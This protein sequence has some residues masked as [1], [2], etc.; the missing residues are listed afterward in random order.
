MKPIGIFAATRWELNAIRRAGPSFT[1]RSVNGIR[2]WVGAVG[3]RSC[4][5][6]RT[7]I[8]P[9]KAADISRNILKVGSLSCMISSGFACALNAAT[10]GDVL[11]GTEVIEHPEGK[12]TRP[13]PCSSSLATHAMNTADAV[14]LAAAAGRFVS[15]ARVMCRGEEKRGI[16]R[17]TQGLGLDM[18]SAALAAAAQEAGISFAIIRTVSDVR[19]EDLPLDFNLFLR[20]TGWISGVASCLR[21]P[22][23]V[24]GLSRLRRQSHLAGMHLTQFYE[25]FLSVET[26]ATFT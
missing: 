2:C 25:K 15:T 7:G 12:H 1:A 11:V 23:T 21:D 24:I 9:E 5:L 6:I 19:D 22:S 8:G 20:P 10:V 13:L 4:W 3:D 18:E 16:A 14:K 26:F 17:V